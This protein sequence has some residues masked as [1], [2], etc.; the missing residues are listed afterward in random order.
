MFDRFYNAIKY[1]LIQGENTCLPAPPCVE[2]AGRVTIS[3]LFANHPPAVLMEK[4]AYDV[5]GHI[6]WRERADGDPPLRLTI[7]PDFGW[8]WLWDEYGAS[9][10]LEGTFDDIPEMEALEREFETW[11]CVF[12]DAGWPAD[13]SP[14]PDIF[15]WP[16]F[17]AQGL[18]LCTRLK[19]LVGE[20]ADIWYEKPFEDPHVNENRLIYLAQVSSARP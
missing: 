16:P 12:E 19:R 10:C 3:A 15:D 11:Q 1:G 4:L 8:S 20:R 17:H 6:E 5:Q 13:G 2:P 14:A 18:E 7:M 9:T